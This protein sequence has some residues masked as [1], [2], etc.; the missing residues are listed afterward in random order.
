M[1]LT[2]EPENTQTYDIQRIGARI[3]IG[4]K[5][6]SDITLTDA[7]VSGT[8]CYITIRSHTAAI[9]EDSSTNGTYV[10][11]V[12]IGKGSKLEVHHGDLL[13]L[14]KPVGLASPDAPGA[15]S[16]VNMRV[17]FGGDESHTGS[18]NVTSLVWKEKI[19]DLKVVASLAE[20][21]A[22]ENDRKHQEALGK[23]FVAEAEVKRVTDNSIELSVRNESMRAEI[24]S[25]RH[26][27]GQS[28]TRADT[29]EQ[30][31]EIL[32]A[33]LNAFDFVE[34]SELRARCSSQNDRIIELER[35][36]ADSM[37]NGRK[38]GANLAAV[39]QALLNTIQMCDNPEMS[40]KREAEI[41][42]SPDVV[43]KRHKDAVMSRT[44]SMSPEVIATHGVP[45][46][47]YPVRTGNVSPP[48]PFR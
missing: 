27:L 6:G 12:K 7:V 23:L 40:N 33:K 4:R 29:A 47:A 24:E 5:Q 34:I 42:R 22:S 16:C 31:V 2:V 13:T 28:D 18:P 46:T 36:N 3:T 25:L 43:Q 17:S 26:R 45:I 9:V 32:Q 44:P 48:T 10:N 1:R 15:Y 14:G 11:G 8:H 39:K 38:L 19:E 41:V 21:E 30:R 37:N 20:H 35:A